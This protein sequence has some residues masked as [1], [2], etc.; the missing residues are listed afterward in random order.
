MMEFVQPIVGFFV[1][2]LLG[3]IFSENIKAIKIKF[4]VIAV[5]I[6][7]VLAYILINL[8]FI[9]DFIDKY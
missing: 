6:Q 7:I 8:T 2:L 1:L 5:I 9:S 3:A 4:L